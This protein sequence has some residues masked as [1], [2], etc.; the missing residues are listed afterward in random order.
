M[1]NE[2]GLT[3]EEYQRIRATP[4][5]RK[6]AADALREVV[7]RKEAERLKRKYPI[8]TIIIDDFEASN[9]VKS[10]QI[11]DCKTCGQPSRSGLVL[12]GECMACWERKIP[13]LKEA[14]E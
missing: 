8:L 6:A 7:L 12:L 9:P 11:G 3:E 1:A 2:R 5:S 13:S 10:I 14:S 4:E